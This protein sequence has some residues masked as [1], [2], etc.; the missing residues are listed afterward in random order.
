MQS[1]TAARTLLS[2]FS[3][4]ERRGPRFSKVREKRYR[5]PWLW[6]CLRTKR[7]FYRVASAPARLWDRPKRCHGDSGL[8]EIQ[9]R[10]LGH[11]LM[12][13]TPLR[14]YMRDTGLRTCRSTPCPA[15]RT[16]KERR[17][18]AARPRPTASDEQV[19]KERATW[20][21]TRIARA[22][23]PGS[24]STGRLRAFGLLMSRLT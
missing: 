20:E 15:W 16:R 5:R 18:G 7:R 13:C 23:L 22:Y 6:S 24:A 9:P 21:D 10:R 17:V 11:V 1:T 14:V 2:R 8:F 19:R 12:P 4:S 3:R